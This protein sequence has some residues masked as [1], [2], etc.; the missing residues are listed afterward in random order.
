MGTLILAALGIL[1]VAVARLGEATK[2]FTRR[3]ELVTFLANANGLRQGGSVTVAGQLAGYV[4]RIELLP[5]GDTTRHIKVVMR[6]DSRLREQIRG[7]SRARLRSLGLLGDKIIDIVPGTPRYAMLAPGDT[8][9]S[10]AAIDYEQMLEQASAAVGD[11]VQLTRTLRTISDGMASGEGTMGQLLTNRSLYD[12]LTGSL[13]RMNTLLGRIERSRGTFGRLMEDPTL[14][15]HLVRTTARL[16]S[17]LV[18][19]RSPDGTFGRLLTDDTLYSRMLSATV[20][21]DS[22]LKLM[23]TGSGLAARMLTD[24]QLYDQLNKTLTDL[25]AIL[26][27]LRRNPGRYTRGMVRVF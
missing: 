2:L 14:Y 8:L 4:G 5:P 6:I 25:N 21:A 3:Y 24:Q 11:L 17:T 20:T 15:E 26:E 12:E 16:D 10:E 22:V 23:T 27:D 13:A 18:Q 7:D 9:P 1:A 19:L